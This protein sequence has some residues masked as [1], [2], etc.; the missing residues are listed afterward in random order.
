MSDIFLNLKLEISSE[1]VKN[2]IVPDLLKTFLV[3][4]K[5]SIN[6]I[7]D[8]MESLYNQVKFLIDKNKVKIS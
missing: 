7:R 5:E 6:N 1:I 8:L 2:G 3:I 4:P